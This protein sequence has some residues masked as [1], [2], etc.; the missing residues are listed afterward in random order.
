MK[1]TKRLIR[2]EENNL[3]NII[4]DTNVLVS[5]LINPHGYPGV[6]IG[7]LLNNKIILCYDSR[8]LF[9]YE[10]VLSYPKFEFDKKDI[11]SLVDFIKEEGLPVISERVDY[12]LKDKSDLPFLEVVLSSNSKYLVTGNIKHYPDNIKDVHIITPA[13]FITNY[14]KNS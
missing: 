9:E 4:L 12:K 10:K 1:S 14:F 8:M 3:M 6:I 7:L 11:Q 2:P 13:Q 5:G